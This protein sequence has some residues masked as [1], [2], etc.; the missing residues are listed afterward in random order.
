[1]HLATTATKFED[2]DETK[3]I[4][5]F[6]SGCV[7]FTNAMVLPSLKS[8]SLY[9]LARCFI[10]LDKFVFAINCLLK[11]IDL[12]FNDWN[13]ILT[14]ADLTPIVDRIEIVKQFMKYCQDHPDA[15]Y[16][17]YRGKGIQMNRPRIV[18]TL[19][20]TE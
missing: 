9:N 13:A 2:V 16:F 18:F 7:A 4:S 15:F 8:R 6:E 5:Y 1:M 20:P 11:S 12:G 14:D 10:K 19:L 3:A 17:G